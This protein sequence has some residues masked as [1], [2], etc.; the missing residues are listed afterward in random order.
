[1]EASW[2]FGWVPIASSYIQQLNHGGVLV[3]RGLVEEYTA[4]SGLV[5]APEQNDWHSWI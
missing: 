1:M 4:T 5:T 3:L 2:Q